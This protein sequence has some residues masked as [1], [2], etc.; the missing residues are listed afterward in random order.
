MEG[1]RVVKF[2][3]THD[4]TFPGPSTLSVNLRVQHEK[5]PHIRYSFA[6]M[7]T[8]HYILDLRKR[9]PT[10]KIFLCKFDIDAAYR[11]CTL[12]SST[13]FE[14]LTMFEDY[15]L[16]ALRMTFGGSPNPALWGV[17]SETTT[18]ICNALLGN[19]YWDHTAVFNPI[20]DSLEDPSSFP[21]NVPFHQ[22]RELAVNLP[23]ND[24][25]KVDIYIDDTIGVAPDIRDVPMWVSRE[26]PLAI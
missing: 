26:I 21:E 16:I 1:N 20:S 18:D 19:Q 3:M 10:T 22:A 24:C 15:L 7:R 23:L 13:A 5:L 14:S 8:I 25:G 17:S 6:L 4:Q 2:W 11:R 9:H 12:S